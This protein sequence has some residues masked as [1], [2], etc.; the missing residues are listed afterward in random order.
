MPYA[1]LADIERYAGGRVKLT[2]LTDLENAR[3]VDTVLV[4]SYIAEA[5]S[6]INSY[7][8]P[9]YAVPIPDADVPEN[10]RT[11]SARL[12]VYFLRESRQALTAA[13]LTRFEAIQSWLRAVRDGKQSLGVDPRLAASTYQKK[14]QTGDRDLEKLPQAITRK[15]FEG[16]L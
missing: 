12:V 7:L 13:D 9:L 10:I 6:W 14:T 2:Q 1:V 8:E 15:R 16:F 5:D 11:M 4:D 3:E